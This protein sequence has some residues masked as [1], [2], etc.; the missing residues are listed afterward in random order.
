MEGCRKADFSDLF[1]VALEDRSVGVR[2]EF[3]ETQDG[4]SEKDLE[5]DVRLLVRLWRRARLWHCVFP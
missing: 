3:M 4:E 5:L 1:G 2:R